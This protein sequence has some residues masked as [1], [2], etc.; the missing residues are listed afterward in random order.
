MSKESQSQG[1]EEKGK[2]Y[3]VKS[4]ESIGLQSEGV[5]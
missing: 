4:W 2:A 3:C 5:R 1:K